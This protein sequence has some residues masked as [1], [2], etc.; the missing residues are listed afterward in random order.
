MKWGLGLKANL[1]W[2]KRNKKMI[3]IPSCL[4]SPFFLLL[5]LLL[6]LLLNSSPHEDLH[7]CAR[8]SLLDPVFHQ[9]VLRAQTDTWTL[10]VTQKAVQSNQ[11]RWIISLPDLYKHFISIEVHFMAAV[12]TELQCHSLETTYW[13]YRLYMKTLVIHSLGWKLEGFLVVHTRW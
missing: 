12:I 2:Q 7:S 11:V 1:R 5:L 9:T 3:T 13:H 8:K 4:F 6:L 10:L